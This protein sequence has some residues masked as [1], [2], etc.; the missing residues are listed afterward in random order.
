MGVSIADLI[1][2]GLPGIAAINTFLTGVQRREFVG[3]TYRDVAG[4]EAYI[5][6]ELNPTFIGTGK[7]DVFDIDLLN[8][9]NNLTDL[10]DAEIKSVRFISDTTD[11]TVGGLLSGPS[12]SSNVKERGTLFF[13]METGRRRSFNWPSVRDDLVIPGGGNNLYQNGGLLGVDVS[14][15][16][17]EFTGEGLTTRTFMIDN[18]NPSTLTGAKRITYRSRSKDRQP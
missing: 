9:L 4:K 12:E 16:A 17:A 5:E 6:V 15:L 8:A 11:Y 3:I 10:S 14:A 7:F 13:E 2:Q 18:M 1:S